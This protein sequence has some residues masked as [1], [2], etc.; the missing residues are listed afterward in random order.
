M[1][2]AT[3]TGFLAVYA[4]KGVVAPAGN[5]QVKR[6]F[7]RLVGVNCKLDGVLERVFGF[8]GD[9]DFG[10]LASFRADFGCGVE[11]DAE[12]VVSVKIMLNEKFCKS[13]EQSGAHHTVRCE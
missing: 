4:Y 12:A 5:A 3:H 8:L 2:F 11:R 10:D 9:S 13:M 6:E 7:V 1:R